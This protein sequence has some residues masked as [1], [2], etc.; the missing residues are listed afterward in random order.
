MSKLQLTTSGINIKSPKGIAL[1]CNNI[2]PQRTFNPTGDLTTSLILDPNAEDVKE[3]IAKLE[4]L[5]AE[6]FAEAKEKLGPAKAKGLQE[7]PVYQPDTDKDGNETGKIVFKFKLGNVDTKKADG[8][9]YQIR[10]YDAQTNRID[11]PPRVGNGSEIR[12]TAFAN[13]YYMATSKEI[14]VSMYWQGMQIIKLVEIGGG[15]DFEAEEGYTIAPP[16]VEENQEI[17][18]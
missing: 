15:D 3:M 1:W 16:T 11:N 17:P 5:R 12:C 9:Q 13:P 6:A 2:E 18:F 4:A 14:G 8:K 7:R 10:T